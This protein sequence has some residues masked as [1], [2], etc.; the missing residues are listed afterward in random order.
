MS[1]EAEKCLSDT[2][3]EII[4]GKTY[5]T[6]RRLDTLVIL[7]KGDNLLEK[8]STLTS[9]ADEILNAMFEVEPEASDVGQEPTLRK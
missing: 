6:T 8:F 4:Q 5:S 7:N 9:G 3:E 1:H 2:G